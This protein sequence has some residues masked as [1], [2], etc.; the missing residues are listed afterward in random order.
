MSS[1]NINELYKES[2][3]KHE[4]RLR[5]FDNILKKIHIRIKNSASNEKMF[6]FY[7]IPEFIIGVPLYDT[8]E[9]KKY[10]IN[11][12]E[13]DRFK[14]LYVEP[15][16]LFISWQVKSSKKIKTPNK[17]PVERKMKYRLIDEYKPMGGFYDDND[18]SSIKN[19]TNNLF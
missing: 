14:L 2:D 11:S 9:L 15:N 18:L 16:W 5:V 6:C 8:N 1:L 19:K 13:K 17:K 10:L 12:L 3:R 4:V 7:Q